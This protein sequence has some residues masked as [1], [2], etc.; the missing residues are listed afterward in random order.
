MIRWTSGASGD[1]IQGSKAMGSP[2]RDS[3]AQESFGISWDLR[4]EPLL[5]VFDI[6]IYYTVLEASTDLKPFAVSHV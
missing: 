3:V 5:V 2:K 1:R 4:T 6:Y